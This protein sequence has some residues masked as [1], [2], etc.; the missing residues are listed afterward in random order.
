MAELE[1]HPQEEEQ[2]TVK[3]VDP[4]ILLPAANGQ[5]QRHESPKAEEPPPLSSSL[6][7]RF[8]TRTRDDTL[9]DPRAPSYTLSTLPSVD[10]I[11]L[12]QGSLV[13]KRAVTEAP[14]YVR[15]Y[16]T[17]KQASTA[18]PVSK[19]TTE[20]QSAEKDGC[21][22]WGLPLA[23]VFRL[24]NEYIKK[25]S[26][27]LQLPYEARNALHA[28]K[29]Q[30]VKGPYTP[31]K[32]PD[33]G[34]FD[35]VGHHIRDQ[36]I[37]LGEMSKE[38]AMGLFCS[39]LEEGDENWK[40]HL[41]NEKHAIDEELRR[42]WAR[43]Q[44]LQ[45][46]VEEKLRREEEERKRAEEEERKRAEEERLKQEQEAREREE[47]EERRREEEKQQEKISAENEARRSSVT[48]ETENQ[49]HTHDTQKP[50]TPTNNEPQAQAGSDQPTPNPHTDTTSD[51]LPTVPPAPS[52]TANPSP[53]PSTPPVAR[54]ST[55]T[56]TSTP[57]PQT[58]SFDVWMQQTSADPNAVIVVP[59]GESSIIRVPTPGP[60]SMTWWEFAVETYD[61]NFGVSFEYTHEGRTN[62]VPILP[63]F[64]Q[65]A[66]NQV[67]RGSHVAEHKG[68]YLLKFDNTY[69]YWRS[70]T[71][72]YR[73]YSKRLPSA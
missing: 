15:D 24:A 63:L 55:S 22:T 17:I 27:R 69:S 25:E 9:L 49:A 33:L 3:M 68:V 44:A 35:W 43:Q 7:P 72:Y 59:R 40:L 71:V 18:G 65:S 16:F 67:I 70:K 61:I 53:N 45:K 28:L 48:E 2:G 41:L 10:N 39:I 6:Q 30:V 31:D 26:G 13:L 47:E 58:P 8:T 52:I 66:T 51:P 29:R 57:T 54:S 23:T 42:E 32:M 50:A 60:R 4:A 34:W 73:V 64:T 20:P 36:W 37:A 1:L 12:Q 14:E 56:G 21:V 46:E 19:Y 38:E 5:T 62:I 11:D